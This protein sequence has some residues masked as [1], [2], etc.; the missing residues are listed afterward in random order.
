MPV[1]IS[2][3]FNN[4]VKHSIKHYKGILGEFYYDF[5]IWEI[6]Y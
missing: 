6:N 5:N 3:S 4:C 2:N 1:S